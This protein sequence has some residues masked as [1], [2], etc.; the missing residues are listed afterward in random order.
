VTTDAV[1]P[2]YAELA[3]EFER[4]AMPFGDIV[5]DI[6]RRDIARLASAIERV[7]R[8]IDDAA[9]D[10]TRQSLWNVVLAGMDGR[11]P[12]AA[13][14]RDLREGID[15]L[16]S[17]G[18]ER[19][20]LSR[21]RRIV[22]KESRTS[23]A[24]RRARSSRAFVPLV[25]REGRLTAALALVVAGGAC[26][27]RFRRFFFRL[28]GPANLI[29]KIVDAKEDHARG[30]IRLSPSLAFYARLFVVLVVRSAG[31][32]LFHPRPLEILRLGLRHLRRGG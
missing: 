31:L 4:L 15:E 9:D 17:I 25:L 16:R 1:R 14:P 11:T 28:G 30:E 32:V 2:E 29:D 12:A 5:D 20:V 6:V 21:L 22:A 27:R 19:N 13:V 23:E 8:V 7:D 26:G 24:M 10:E 18:E 3:R